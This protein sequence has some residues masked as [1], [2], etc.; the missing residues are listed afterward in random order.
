MIGL[1]SQVDKTLASDVADALGLAVP[2]KPEQPVNHSIP[3]DGVESKFQPKSKDPGLKN[4]GALSM[5]GTI[6]NTIKSRKIAILTADGADGVRIAK[7]KSALLQNGATAE[8]IAPKLGTVMPVKGAAIQADKSL[9]T[10]SSVLYD[11]V[12]IPGGAKAISLLVQKPEAAE[13]ISQ[14][15]KHCKAICFEADA[16]PLIS[17]TMLG[18]DLTSSP[19]Y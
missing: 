16:E 15:Y 5:A 9:M 18:E 11:A 13:F 4:S 1:L 6:K 2:K 19:G 10:V 8:I 7:M 3:A 14:A 12:Y 17:K